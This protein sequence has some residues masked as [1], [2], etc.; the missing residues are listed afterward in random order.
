MNPLGNTTQIPTP[1]LVSLQTHLAAPDQ[2]WPYFLIN[3][4]RE[5]GITNE[6]YKIIFLTYPTVTLWKAYFLKKLELIVNQSEKLGENYSLR[7]KS[8]L[9][10]LEKDDIQILT[11]CSLW[12]G[13]GFGERVREKKKICISVFTKGAHLHKV[14]F[15]SWLFWTSLV[16][17]LYFLSLLFDSCS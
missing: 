9:Y 5:W 4:D 14:D 13:Q 12:G 7:E 8:L 15:G 17:S 3:V 2:R 1:D 11:D 6:K 16:F 10:C